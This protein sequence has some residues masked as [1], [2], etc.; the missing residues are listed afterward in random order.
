VAFVN[1]YT[2]ELSARDPDALSDHEA[3]AV[4][5]TALPDAVPISANVLVRRRRIASASG[6]R[7]I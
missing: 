5:R 7:K 1:R 4:A 3:I 2:G 6:S